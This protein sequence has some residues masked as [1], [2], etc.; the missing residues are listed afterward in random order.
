VNCESQI[1]SLCMCFIFA[2]ENSEEVHFR[3]VITD[4]RSVLCQVIELC[5][6]AQV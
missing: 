5:V 3:L 2:V 1:V 6:V 4:L